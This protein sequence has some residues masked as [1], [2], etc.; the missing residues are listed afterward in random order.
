MRLVTSSFTLWGAAATAVL[1]TSSV[2]FFAPLTDTQ[3]PG[4]QPLQAT[5]M[6]NPGGCSGCH[7]YYDQAVEPYENWEGSMMSQAGRDPVFWAALD[8]PEQRKLFADILSRS[9]CT[10]T[11]AVST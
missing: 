3:Q 5:L 6:S 9:S 7:G 8:Y 4:T 10:L 11:S 2:P 1:L